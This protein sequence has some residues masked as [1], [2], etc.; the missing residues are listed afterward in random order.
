MSMKIERWVVCAD[1][2]GAMAEVHKGEAIEAMHRAICCC[3]LKAADCESSRWLCDEMADNDN[4]SHTEDGVQHSFTYTHEC[5]SIT[6]YRLTRDADEAS[7]QRLMDLVRYARHYLHDADLITDEEFASL[8]A[9]SEKGLRV[10]RLGGY[11]ALYSRCFAA[12][13][14]VKQLRETLV[15]RDGII[16]GLMDVQAGRVKSLSEIETELATTPKEQ[17]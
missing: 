11:D 13:A 15:E 9:D 2:E 7:N 5:G 17:P 12:E 10:M 14:Q 6:I 3:S 16:R 1:G 8:V 4:W